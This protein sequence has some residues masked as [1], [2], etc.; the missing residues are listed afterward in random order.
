MTAKKDNSVQKKKSDASGYR[1][2]PSNPSVFTG[3]L[4]FLIAFYN[5][6]L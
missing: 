2:S 4:L 6:L 1:K 5:V 3:L